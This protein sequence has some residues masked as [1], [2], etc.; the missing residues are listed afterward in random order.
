MSN[1]LQPQGIVHEILQ[2]RILEKVAVPFSR[3]SSQPRTPTLQAD[4]LPAEPPGKSK[5]AGVGSLSLLQRIFPSPESNWG[6]LHC[7][8]ILYQLSYQGICFTRLPFSKPCS[9][10]NSLQEQSIIKWKNFSKSFQMLL[11]RIL[12]ESRLF[13]MVYPVDF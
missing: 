10:M 5:N 8:R 13:E 4:P 6:F 9:E 11:F 12:M 3:G 2:A 1:S 7:R